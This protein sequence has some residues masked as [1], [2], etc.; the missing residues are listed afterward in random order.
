MFSQILKNLREGRGLTQAQLAEKIGVDRTSVGKY[1]TTSTTPSF[2][3]LKAIASVFGVSTD[4]LLGSENIITE[5]DS[6]WYPYGG[7][8]IFGEAAMILHGFEKLDELD[9][10]QVV[11]Y[12]NFLLSHEKYG[13]DKQQMHLDDLAQKGGDPDGEHN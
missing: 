12:M 8:Y 3:T 10:G 2:E 1:E 4:Y 9:R 11:S 13:P 6:V 5:E 7:G